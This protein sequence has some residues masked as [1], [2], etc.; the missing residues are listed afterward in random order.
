MLLLYLCAA[1]AP[2]AC[3]TT[4][5]TLPADWRGAASSAPYVDSAAILETGN[6]ALDMRLRLIANAQK[7]FARERIFM[8][9]MQ[10]GRRLPRRFS[11]RRIAG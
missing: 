2:Y 11:T 1:L 3:Q 5:A 8:P 6:E 9:W 7:A 4:S 10:A